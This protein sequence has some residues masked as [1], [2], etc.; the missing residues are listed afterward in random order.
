MLKI[1]L[2]ESS[3]KKNQVIGF[4]KREVLAKRNSE[5]FR[6][7]HLLIFRPGLSKFNFG[8]P[9]PRRVYPGGFAENYFRSDVSG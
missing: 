6:L 7:R 5:T 4:S 9:V 1:N 8:Y 3:V 2:Y